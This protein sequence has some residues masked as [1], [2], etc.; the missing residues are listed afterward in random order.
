MQESSNSPGTAFPRSAEELALQPQ[1]LELANAYGP[2]T[3]GTWAGRNVSIGNEEALA[4]RGAFMASLIRASIL[5]RYSLDKISKMTLVDVG[6]YDGWLICQLEDLPF[7]RLIGIE[8]RKKNLDKG[9]MIRGLLGIETRCEFRQGS[10]ESLQET[11]KGELADVVVCA[12]LFHH[13]SSTADGIARLHE[14]CSGF[15]FLETICFPA[16]LE[17]ERLR[18]ALEL[19]DLPYFFGSQKFGVTGHKLESGYY[20]GSATQMSV[21]SLPSVETLKMFLEVQ[22]FDDVR[23][24]ADPE[25]YSNA[26]AGGYRKFSAV[27]IT[28]ARRDLPR[29]VN[30]WISEYEGGL[31]RTLLPETVVGSLYT[32]FC[33]GEKTVDDTPLG[34]LAIDL[35]T[36]EGSALDRAGLR[37]RE[38]VPNRYT[39]EILKNL[40][41]APADKIALEY[42]KS[43]LAAGRHEAA[44]QSLFRITRHLNAD[45]RAVYRAF[46]ILTWS[47]RERGDA[48]GADRYEEL[49]LIANPLFPPDLIRNSRAAFVPFRDD[50]DTL[51]SEN[52]K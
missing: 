5:E 28:A 3:H 52:I 40:R 49:C 15:L 38:M 12:G 11:M 44:E 19:K 51:P 29:D 43:L 32:R 25:S 2:Y 36:A 24:V 7:A 21:V 18:D 20:D 23:V 26:V 48:A 4:G 10:I 42:G 50:A 14:I 8:P 16:A 46:C 37:L 35:I 1:A 41:F 13:L 27:C 22:G 6:C 39:L 31:V 9:K 45:W 30:H 33:L 47:C 17:D 34:Q